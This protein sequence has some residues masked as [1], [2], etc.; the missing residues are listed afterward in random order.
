[1]RFYNTFYISKYMFFIHVR[2]ED[3][4]PDKKLESDQKNEWF[5]QS[6]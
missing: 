3:P 5:S 4:K 2:K 6:T 1:M